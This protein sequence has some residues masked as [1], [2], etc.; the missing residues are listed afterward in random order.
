MKDVLPWLVHWARHASTRDVSPVLAALVGP[1][2]KYFFLTVHS[3]TSF[4]PFARKLDRKSSWVA[5][6]LICVSVLLQA[7]CRETKHEKR[8]LKKTTLFLLSLK[9]APFPLSYPSKT[10]TVQSLPSLLVF[11]SGRCFAYVS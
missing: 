7:K 8:F 3:F 5:C 1:F 2:Q 10:A 11:V 6:L 9:L 4:V